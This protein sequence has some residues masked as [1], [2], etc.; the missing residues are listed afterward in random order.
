MRKT[1]SRYAPAQGEGGGTRGGSCCY[2]AV[3]IEVVVT[4]GERER[5]LVNVLVGGP[6][7]ESARVTSYLVLCSF[8]AGDAA[9]RRNVNV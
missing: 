6:L 7:V 5:L 3:V 8:A 4:D 1:T 9:L 2:A